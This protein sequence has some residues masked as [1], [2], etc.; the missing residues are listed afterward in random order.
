MNKTDA[1]G[2]RSISHAVGAARN[3]SRENR[4]CKFATETGCF[5]ITVEECLAS[6]ETTRKNLPGHYRALIAIHSR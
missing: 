4:Y 2:K 5:D 1:R 6:R 3:R